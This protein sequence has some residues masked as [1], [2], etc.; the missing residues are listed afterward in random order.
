MVKILS[1]NFVIK[2]KKITSI[3][4]PFTIILKLRTVISNFI[5]RRISLI[6]N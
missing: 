2:N 5:I 1:V 4:D 3:I 6:E